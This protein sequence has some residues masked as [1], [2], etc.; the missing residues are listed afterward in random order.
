MPKADF[1]TLR[2]WHLL[3]AGP[4]RILSLDGGGVRG[5][6]SLAF[7]ERIESI[8]RSRAGVAEFRLV[9]YFDL[10]G[11]TSTGA[12]IATGMAIGYSAKQ[13]IELYLNLAE[14]GFKKSGWLGG[15]WSPK[16]NSIALKEMIEEKFGGIRLGSEQICC[17][18]GIVTKRIDSGSVWLFHNHP[19]GPYFAPQGDA[20]G[21]TP[22]RDIFL[23]DILR[24]STAAP[25][26]F[27]P[28][29][30]QIAPEKRGLFVDGGM[31]PHANPALILM[32]L[33]TLKGYGFRWPLGDDKLMMVSVGTGSQSSRMNVVNADRHPAIY[34][35]IESLISLTED[36]D[37]L[38]QL[39]LQWASSSPTPW[40]I[41]GEVGS[42][43]GDVIGGKPLLHY[44]RY[45]APLSAEWLAKHLNLVLQPDEVGSIREMDRPENVHRLLE[46][47]RQAAKQQVKPEHLPAC[48]DLRPGDLPLGQRAGDFS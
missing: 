3:S 29:W 43:E 34:L 19:R 20:T 37:R 36:T 6:L 41:D 14:R 21:F 9:D 4:K 7:L 40:L 18:L 1:R 10:M 45:D 25:T 39:L 17:G 12:L 30:I 2:E 26:Y 13:M 47:G 48:F 27:A 38:G 16:F 5:I 33:A 28:E 42:L 8:L 31:S 32:L 11:G 22:N 24:A 35:A 15:F 44:L 23:T 46:I